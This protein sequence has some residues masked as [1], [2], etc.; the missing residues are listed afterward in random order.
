M[1]TVPAAGTA[2]SPAGGSACDGLTAPGQRVHFRSD[3]GGTHQSWV[4]T[5]FDVTAGPDAGRRLVLAAGRHLAG[6]RP[7]LLGDGRRSGDRAA[8]R[9]ARRRRRTDR[10]SSVQLA[11]RSPVTWTDGPWAPVGSQLDR[12]RRL[13]DRSRDAADRRCGSVW[14]D[15]AVVAIGVASSRC[16]DATLASL[17]RR[18][19][20]DVAWSA[21]R[22]R[23]SSTPIPRLERARS[24]A[25]SIAAQLARRAVS[26][27]M[28]ELVLAAPGDPAL[29][30]CHGPARDRRPLA[31]PV[32]PRCDDARGR[33]P[34]PRRRAA[35]GSVESWTTGRSSLSR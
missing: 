16:S 24:V 32:E 13:A 18:C 3:V 4:T 17:D 20:F 25:R 5:T 8:S 27:V 9:A 33:D 2:G 31:R 34:P 19:S 12:G 11:G 26:D 21:C 14:R 10:S 15:R 35:G 7:A 29:D 22:G 6:P 30:A 1:A 28:P 23:E